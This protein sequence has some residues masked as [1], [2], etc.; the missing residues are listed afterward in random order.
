LSVPVAAVLVAVW[1]CVWVENF[2]PLRE[3]VD[4]RK[5]LRS[6]T[7][8]TVPVKKKPDI[9]SIPA[10]PDTVVERE[11]LKQLDSYPGGHPSKKTPWVALIIDDFGPPGTLRM[12]EGF[13]AL[14]FDLTFSILPGNLKSILIGRKIHDVGA[15]QFIHL[16]MEPDEW[17]SMDE[18]DMVMVGID[19]D[20]LKLILDRV[21]SDLPFAVG[22]N[23]HMGSKATLDDPLMKLFA[24]ELKARGLIFID[25]RT[26]PRSRAYANTRAVGVPVLGR[27]IFIDNYRD[28]SAIRERLQ[29]LFGIARRRG[30]AI[31]IG[32]ATSKTLKALQAATPMIEESGVKFVSASVLVNEVTK[33]RQRKNNEI[34]GIAEQVE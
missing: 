25:S 8:R 16:P 7:K 23:N 18:R 3:T 9:V 34:T 22:M 26:A 2:Q 28:A 24:G 4:Q 11:V 6:E 5:T 17:E 14:P 12:I 30:W 1:F 31:G 27:D 20:E 21:T 29:E 15:E 13:L 19:A 33:S 10:T 32:H